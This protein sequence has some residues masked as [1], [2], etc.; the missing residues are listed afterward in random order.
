MKAIT[1]EPKKPG[2]ARLMDMPEPD[3]RDGS[4]LVEAIAVGVCGTDVEITEGKYGWAPPGQSHLILGHESLGRVIDPGTSTGFKKGDLVVGIVRRPD[5]VPC[6]NCAVGEWDMCRNGLY[7]ERGIKE[8]HGYMSERWRIEPEYAVKVDSSLGILGVLLEPTTVVT[9]AMEQIGM[10]GRR[11]YWEPKSILVTGAGPI[12]LLAAL[13]LKL[14]GISEVHV[15]DRMESGSK[16]DLV[17]ELGATYHSGRV[18][19]LNFEPDAIIECTGVGQVIA[20][21]I[22]KI[23]ASGI[24]CLT[25]VG[26]GGAIGAG[27]LADVAAAAVLRNNVIVGS[28]N[29]NKRQWYRAGLT[30]AKADR[31]WLAKLIT[32]REK[33]ENFMKALE[34]NPDDIKVVIQFSEV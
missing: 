16:P 25:G 32:R 12:G 7:T 13:S 5:P 9:K 31:T 6:P 1:V 23:G 34:R 21:C 11:S 2:T 24:I 29:A 27:V 18:A 22:H 15:L 33:P 10:I 19:D 28:V 14:W 20:D 17:R 8:I 26:Q 30:L 4:I 3:I